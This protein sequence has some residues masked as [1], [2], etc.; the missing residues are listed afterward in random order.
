MNEPGI[1]R[2]LLLGV[3]HTA[4]GQVHLATQANART[5]LAISVGGPYVQMRKGDL[6]V[7]NEDTCLAL[8]AGPL[9]VLAVCDGH[10]GHW[11]SH[12]IAEVLAE[13]E[14]LPSD[15]LSALRLVASLAQPIE[16]DAVDL[17]EDLLDA[18]TTLLLA[19]VDRT[20]RRLFG[21][22]Y[23]DS[24]IFVVSPRGLPV[25]AN[26]KN[27]RYVT[28]WLPDSL[29]PRAA[30]EFVADFVP[31]DLLVACTDGIDECHYR[32]PQT[33]VG[34]EQIWSLLLASESLPE[35]FAG[36]LAAM[37]L[38]GVGGHPGGQDNL[39]VVVTKG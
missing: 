29:D 4:Y 22:S 33:S 19:V 21:I 31:G 36:R 6:L 18:R 34:S 1:E 39:A 15:P 23:G 28:P 12:G 2:L 13:V 8:D 11:A 37:A 14:S 17:P 25:R 5:A 9:T 16:E 27:E 30:H 38:Q 32:S 26:A 10:H 35:A 7:P 3:D 20:R 24:S